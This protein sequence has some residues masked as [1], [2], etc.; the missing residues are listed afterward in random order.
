[1]NEA[2]RA[3]LTQLATPPPR[4]ASF[5]THTVDLGRCLIGNLDDI[6]EAWLLKTDSS[7]TRPIGTL[8]GF[9]NCSGRI[10]WRRDKCASSP[11][12]VPSSP[13]GVRSSGVH[14]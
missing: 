6:S 5:H 2:L 3:G 4:R 8:L 13:F 14:L 9:Q 1:V 12:A 7:F 11:F 10:H